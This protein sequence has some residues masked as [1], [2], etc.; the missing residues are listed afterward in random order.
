MSDT[1]QTA[2]PA[3]PA[4]EPVQMPGHEVYRHVEQLA[5]MVAAQPASSGQAQQG[6]AR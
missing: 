1:T 2:P 4:P 5:A 3:Q 6:G